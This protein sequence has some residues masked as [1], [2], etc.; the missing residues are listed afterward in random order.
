MERADHDWL[1][2]VSARCGLRLC[3]G[4]GLWREG[5]EWLKWADTWLL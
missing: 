2:S 1:Q 5:A 3:R 4:S